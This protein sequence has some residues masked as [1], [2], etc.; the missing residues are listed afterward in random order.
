MHNKGDTAARFEYLS[1]FVE[2][3]HSSGAFNHARRE[4]TNLLLPWVKL[5]YLQRPAGHAGGLF[6]R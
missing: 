4:G 2:K 6:A 5:G 1:E 3:K